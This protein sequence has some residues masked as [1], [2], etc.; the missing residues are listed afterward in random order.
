MGITAFQLVLAATHPEW[1]P[2]INLILLPALLII[3]LA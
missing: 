1:I 2:F 3:L